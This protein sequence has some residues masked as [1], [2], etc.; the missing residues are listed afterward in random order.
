MDCNLINYTE[1][2]NIHLATTNVNL[3]LDPWTPPPPPLTSS[4]GNMNRPNIRAWG[5]IS[6]YTEFTASDGNVRGYSE[7]HVICSL[8]YR[9]KINKLGK[10]YIDISITTKII[11]RHLYIRYSNS[12]MFLLASY[13]NEHFHNSL[14]TPKNLEIKRENLK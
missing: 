14:F 10:F 11:L 8:L 12:K 1:A 7:I 2:V 9:H 4:C 6:E 5:K 3:T 13:L